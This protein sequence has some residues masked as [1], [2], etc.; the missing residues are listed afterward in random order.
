MFK[1]YGDTTSPVAITA[2]E[3]D[4]YL[5]MGWFRMGQTIFTCNFLNFN[6]I[7][8]TAIWLRVE[9]NDYS[10]DNTFKKLQKVN[11]KF[12]TVIR[13]AT[14]TQ[15]K[16]DL[17]TKYKTGITFDTSI[18][19]S[20]LLLE[21]KEHNIYNTYEVC[22][23]DNEK[24]IA[25]GYFDLGEKSAAGIV[26]FYDPEYKKHSLGKYLIYNKIAYCKAQNFTHFYPGYF[27]PNYPLF[28]YKLGIGKQTM[29]F[30]NL[31][32]NQWESI[33]KFSP[34]N[35]LIDSM[36]YHLLVME[37]LLYESKVKFVKQNYEF[38]NAN[39]ISDL[40][41]LDMFDYPQFIFVFSPNHVGF[42]PIIV[43]DV[44][45]QKYRLVKC[46][47]T[48][49]YPNYESADGYFGTHLMKIS[50]DL[51]ESED[52]RLFPELFIKTEVDCNI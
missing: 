48:H 29:Q 17:Y 20:A 13:P 41:G 44:I 37:Y 45:T 8:Y 52:P 24:L 38:Y 21:K 34:F 25:T 12:E 5:E 1:N 51:F 9:L 7:F 18:S 36:S 28:D 40:Q 46:I 3:L 15:E 11:Q 23:Y 31:K 2:T 4:Q 35:N 27:A 6:R 30:L 22:V 42:N 49:Y 14:I 26:S 50:E 32:N 39:C 43:F 33:H 19:L 16:E 47:S 10:E